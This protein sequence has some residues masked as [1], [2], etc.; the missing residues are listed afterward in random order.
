MLDF[1]RYNRVKNFIQTT[2]FRLFRCGVSA[3]D[4]ACTIG[5]S[6]VAGEACRSVGVHQ[7]ATK[8]QVDPS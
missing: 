7:M 5:I 3:L 8:K 4:R 2:I 6:F 1:A